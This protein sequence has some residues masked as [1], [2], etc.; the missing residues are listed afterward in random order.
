MNQRGLLAAAVLIAVFPFLFLD[1][2]FLLPVLNLNNDQML[3]AG[4]DIT[5]RLK[6][7]RLAQHHAP[8]GA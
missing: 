1:L 7:Y 6:R 4:Y 5:S 8:L 2:W 3:L